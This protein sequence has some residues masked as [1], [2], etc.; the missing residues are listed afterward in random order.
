MAPSKN[1]V[2]LGASFSGL[3]LAHYLIKHLPADY[4]VTLIN[5]S[6]HL[7]WN[8]A[9][10]RAVVAPELLGK[11]HPDLFIPIL[12]SLEKYPATRFTFIQGK[13]V[14]S[15]PATNTVTIRTCND[16]DKS[17]DVR[18]VSVEYAHLVIATGA[19]AAGGDWGFKATEK[20]TYTDMHAVVERTRE[21]I[22]AAERIVVSG[23]GATGVELAGEIAS[24]Y[25][26][27][28]K[29]VTILSSGTG[30]LPMVREDVGKAAKYHLEKMGVEVRD[31]VKVSS[32]SKTSRGSEIVLSSG[33][34]IMADL[35]IPT[36]GVSPN[37]GFLPKELLDNGGWVVT[38]KYLRT[39]S[40]ENVWAI[41]DITHWGNK[42]LTTLEAMFNVLS[43]NLLLSIQGK[44]AELKEY[45]H[46]DGL[47]LIIPMGT[48]FAK[49]TGIFVSFR[50][51]GWLGW[52][53]KGRTYLVEMARPLAEG[54]VMPGGKKM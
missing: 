37:S 54:K 32:E 33:E 12:P 34:T 36:W 17:D 35:H 44:S 23:A 14:S 43:A 52:L 2:I 26:G 22:A 18:D 5:P 49:S 8:I 38:D 24:N 7:Y 46:K 30:L 47:L 25:Y 16:A 27:K 42:K 39:P 41:G 4:T 21:A 10:P 45:N 40:Y 20:G 6:T 19:S 11:N 31:N 9:S 29:T 1:I 48:G 50:V 13:A 53:L 28:G 3:P 15:S 51:W